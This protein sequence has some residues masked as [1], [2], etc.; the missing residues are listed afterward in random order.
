MKNGLV[1]LVL[2]FSSRAY[3]CFSGV[4]YS[5]NWNYSLI[6][7]SI[8]FMLLVLSIIA[9][10]F[11]LNNKIYIPIIICFFTA[12]P[13]CLSILNYGNGDCGFQLKETS[14]WSVYSMLVVFAFESFQYIRFKFGA[15]NT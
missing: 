15:D 5:E 10:K 13:A 2:L 9:R 8:S 4:G 12:I 1:L 11:R 6:V 3:A 14:L 7:L